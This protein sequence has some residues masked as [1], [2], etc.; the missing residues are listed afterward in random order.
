MLSFGGVSLFDRMERW[1]GMVEWPHPWSALRRPI[2][3]VFATFNQETESWYTV[4][5]KVTGSPYIL[6]ENWNLY[7]V[8]G[9]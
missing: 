1:N 4:Y 2:P 6:S 7:Y 9:S 8:Y 3:T 5:A